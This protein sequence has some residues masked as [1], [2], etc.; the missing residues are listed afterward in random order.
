MAGNFYSCLPLQQLTHFMTVLSPILSRQL[1]GMGTDGRIVYPSEV[2]LYNT[3]ND[4][5]TFSWIVKHLWSN[6]EYWAE[7]I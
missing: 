5:L 3:Y 4:Q 7:F 1:G 2:R 6:S